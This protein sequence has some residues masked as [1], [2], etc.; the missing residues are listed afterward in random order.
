MNHFY[1]YRFTSS[2]HRDTRCQSRGGL[3]LLHTATHPHSVGRTE[4][5]LSMS[6]PRI[7]S[8][9]YKNYKVSAVMKAVAHFLTH[10]NLLSY[11]YDEYM[12]SKGITNEPE[13][14]QPSVSQFLDI[15]V[16]QY[17]MNHP[18]QKAITNGILEKLVIVCNMPLSVV[19]HK[20]FRDFLK[21]VDPKYN[22]VCRKTLTSKTETVAGLRRDKLKTQ[23]SNSDSVSVT[24]DIWSDRRMRGFLG[25]TVHYME[26]DQ[27]NIQLKSNLLACDRFKGS[28]TG[29][30][31]CEQFEAIC[32]EYDIKSKLDYVITDNAANMR[33]AFTVCF[34]SE[35]GEVHD[36]DHLDD[37]ELWHD[38]SPDNQEVVDAAM[39]RK[40][41]LQCFA[42]TLQLVVGD[43]LKDT[44]VTTSSLS[45][46]SKLS[47]L[48]H[49]S[50]TF[51]EEFEAA[52]GERNSIPAAVNTRWNSTLRQ[53]QAALRCDHLKL[54]SVLEKV[55]HREL[56]FTAR[57]WSLLKELV[58]IL[59]PFA[60]ATHMT[61]GEKLVTI[62]SVVPSVLA[63]NHHLEKMIPQVRFLG[64]LV[65]SLQ[66]SLKNRFLG[67]FVNVKMA[68]AQY[69][70]TVP[71]SDPVY[72]KAA[73]LDP[74]FALYWV[75][76]HEGD[77]YL[78][79]EGL[80]AAYR[81]RQRKDANATP[82][83]QLSHYLN[84]CEGQ[85]VLSF[86]AMHMKALPS[87]FRVAIRVLAVPATSAPVERV[88]SHGDI[89][90][91]PHR[92]QMTD[93][94]LVNETLMCMPPPQTFTQ[95]NSY[96]GSLSHKYMQ[97]HTDAII[98]RLAVTVSY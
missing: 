22:S 38:L 79:E 70:T 23:L 37:P 49:T 28:H 60:E 82:A 11:R 57:E 3:L 10:A 77:E 30:R 58:D 67:I 98:A 71:F 97:A 76:H 21:I 16:G 8:F 45:K 34:P 92:A 94:L 9:A 39:A 40:Q 52:Y 7:I 47:S 80:F 48:L 27:D 4:C 88:F 73:A 81:K 66:E 25:V 90:M 50:T 12:M 17:S 14:Q 85:S 87:L 65:R 95:S 86:W 93:R 33:K 24:V 1:S 55:G 19:E 63:L 64:S 36:D 68:T 44:K 35:E 72:L 32:H 26:I 31:I 78:E 13:P 69:G 75:D 59:K 46:L 83:L 61:Q 2:D 18:Q 20:S 43:G 51:K 84:L 6:Q 74:A 15:C 53:V 41:R 29:E 54:S 91:R 5:G 56:T 42:H 96:H 62:S 89:I